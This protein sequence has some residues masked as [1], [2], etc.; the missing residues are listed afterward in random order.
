VNQAYQLGIIA[1]EIGTLQ[2]E[3]ASALAKPEG[4]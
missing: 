2:R 1:E 3:I 4:Q